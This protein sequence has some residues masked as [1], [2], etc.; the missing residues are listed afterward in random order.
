MFISVQGLFMA[1]LTGNGVVA[2]HRSGHIRLTREKMGRQWGH[3]GCKK[4]HFFS[5]QTCQISCLSFFERLQHLQWFTSWSGNISFDRS[6]PTFSI[7]A[8]FSLTKSLNEALIAAEKERQKGKKEN[9]T[10]TVGSKWLKRQESS[11]SIHRSI[12]DQLLCNLPT[13][14]PTTTGQRNGWKNESLA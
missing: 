5:S 11:G 7:L 6:F 8:D 4:I 12:Q 10:W 13:V 9:T 3:E 2:Q 1:T 14:F